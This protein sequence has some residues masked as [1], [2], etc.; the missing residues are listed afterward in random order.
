MSL[1]DERAS[2]SPFWKRGVVLGANGQFGSLLVELLRPDCKEVFG[3]DIRAVEKP[4]GRFLEADA[5]HPSPDLLEILAGADLVVSAVPGSMVPESLLAVAPTLPREALLLDM[6]SVKLPVEKALL[7]AGGAC[8]LLSI[9][10]MFR[11]SVGFRGSNV[12]VVEVP[13]SGTAA[14]GFCRWLE[15]TGAQL[16]YLSAAEHDRITSCVQAATHAALLV[17]GMTL[18][19]MGYEIDLGLRI[20]TPPHRALLGLLSRL[21][22]GDEDVYLAIQRDNAM[23]GEA[24]RCMEKLG[25][26]ID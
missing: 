26:Q 22:G 15:G 23:A 19:E 24:R 20:A 3:V 18:A 13:R 4:A 25:T 1:A 6:A 17:F 5:T 8:E 2:S 9:H 12:A 16:T 7:E 21:A 11:A 10:P 14:R